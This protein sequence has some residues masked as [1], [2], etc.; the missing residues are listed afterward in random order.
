MF[1]V[2]IVEDLDE[3]RDIWR[4]I[5]PQENISDLWEIRDC[6]H[7]NFRRPLHFIVAENSAGSCGLLPLTWVE[8]RQ[9]YGYFPGETW[10][11]K[12]WLEQNR[13]FADDSEVYRALLEHCPSQYHLRYL[14]P[15]DH[16][17]ESSHTVD[18][19][20][21]L[22]LPPKYSY[23]MENYFQ[24]FSHKSAKRIKKDVAALENLGIQYRCDDLSDFDILMNL[25]LQRFDSSSY[26]FD[27]RFRNSFNDL[28]HFLH[29]QGWLRI[30]TVLIEGSAAAVD[31][32]CVHNGTYT[33]L[34]GGT[35][36]AYPGVAKLI[37]LHHMQR[38]CNERLDKVDFLCGDFSWK[39]LFHLMPRP[40]Y[41][42]S[43]VAVQAAHQEDR[44]TDSAVDSVDFRRA[45]NA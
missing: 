11:G 4:R 9:C 37:N 20:G 33:L 38:A 2:R 6:F 5:Y 25:N 42:L 27:D 23:D 45:A 21:Y 40:L 44:A 26:F 3:C 12:T 7:K 8:E 22:F 41:V 1:Q 29:E 32:G 19:I 35:N 14:L 43:N 31:M 36:G 34:A 28:M 16:I 13:I 18:E 30:T 10:Q 39:S 17:A 24:E 15:I